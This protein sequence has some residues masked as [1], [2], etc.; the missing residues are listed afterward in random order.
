MKTHYP[1]KT[2]DVI[3]ACDVIE[4]CFSPEKALKEMHRILKD[5]G[6]ITIDIPLEENFNR[7]I[8]HGHSVLFYNAEKFENLVNSI[9]FFIVKKD[10][11]KVQ[12]S[13]FLLR[14]R[15]DTDKS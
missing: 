5:E 12:N 9:G 3:S 8:L 13:L 6:R 10:C 4:H 1:D 15:E 7:N 14:K 2:F 11:I